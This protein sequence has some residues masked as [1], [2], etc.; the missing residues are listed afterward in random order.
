MNKPDILK[1]DRK[2]ED[3]TDEEIKLLTRLYP[4]TADIEL[5]RKFRLKKNEMKRVQR[6]FQKRNI[7]IQKDDYFLSTKKKRSQGHIITSAMKSLTESERDEILQFYESGAEPVDLMKELISIQAMRYV[8]GFAIEQ[9]NNG[10]PLREVNNC[11]SELRQMIKDL[12]ELEVGIVHKHGV[13]D[14]F[15]DL[16]LKAQKKDDY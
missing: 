16:V 10:Y 7:Y 1:K 8:K 5:E 14:S 11:A 9:A 13:D 4:I 2:L 3:L 15:A 12:H 6:F